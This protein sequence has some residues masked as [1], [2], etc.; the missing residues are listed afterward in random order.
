MPPH[1]PYFVTADA[2][3]TGPEEVVVDELDLTMLLE[4]R[5][6]VLVTRVVLVLAVLMLVIEEDDDLID[7]D[8]LLV[9]GVGVTLDVTEMPP[10]LLVR[11]KQ[12]VPV[13]AR[14]NH[15]S[16]VSMLT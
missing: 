15:A 16:T 7:K 4:L 10:P 12:L 13:Q 6:L 2:V 11:E 9:V 3:E 8:D 14:S 5:V 1:F